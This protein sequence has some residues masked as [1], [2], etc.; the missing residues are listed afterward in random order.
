MTGQRI[1]LDSLRD[2]TERGQDGYSVQ[3]MFRRTPISG[4][5]QSGPYELIASLSKT[6]AAAINLDSFELA[7]PRLVEGALKYI[8]SDENT[9][10]ELPPV[11]EVVMD[12]S[13]SVRRKPKDSEPERE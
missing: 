9:R 11:E 3:I 13:G 6:Q 7:F 4:S 8:L 2:I 5:G 10:R 1:I 12:K